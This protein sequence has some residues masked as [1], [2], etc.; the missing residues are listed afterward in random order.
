MVSVD[1]WFIIIKKLIKIMIDRM[2]SGRRN[3]P[4]A[5]LL[6]SGGLDSGLAGKILLALGI[7]VTALHATSP[8]C[9]CSGSA[10][11]LLGRRSDGG[12]AW[13]SACERAQGRGLLGTGQAPAVRPGQWRQSLHRLPHSCLS[14]GPHVHG[15]DGCRVR[16]HGRGAR[17]KTHVP[18]PTGHGPDRA[19][20]RAFG[21]AVAASFGQIFSADPSRTRGDH[22]PVEAAGH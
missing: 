8:F 3:M 13:Y 6:L 10:G 14:T 5:V 18:A 15:G 20:V 9:R 4:K 21:A 17:A 12:A 16:G 11:G 19:G 7:E 2:A 1:R 22:P